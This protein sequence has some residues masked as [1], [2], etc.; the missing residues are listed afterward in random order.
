MNGCR[1][2]KVAAS[3]PHCVTIEIPPDKLE[4]CDE[5]FSIHRRFSAGSLRGIRRT[6][7]IFFFT[8][9]IAG[10]FVPDKH[11]VIPRSAQMFVLRSTSCFC[12]SARVLLRSWAIFMTVWLEA[13]RPVRSKG[14]RCFTWSCSFPLPLTS[15]DR[16]CS[17]QTLWH[18][19]EAPHFVQA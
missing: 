6:W 3:S 10:A 9:C 4:C 1:K 2:R 12:G 18:F 16:T 11:G 8:C 13:L 5:V 7:C 14:P 19:T 17:P 15:K